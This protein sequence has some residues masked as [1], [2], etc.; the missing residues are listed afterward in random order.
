[1]PEDIAVMN[2]ITVS[3]LV[4]R[5]LICTKPTSSTNTST[6]VSASAIDA[7]RSGDARPCALVLH[8]FEELFCHIDT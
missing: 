6:S 8:R 4:E 1:M 5:D 3:V 7:G 2:P